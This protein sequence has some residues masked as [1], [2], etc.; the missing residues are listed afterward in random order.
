MADTLWTC[1]D[2][3]AATG[4]RASQPF[5]ASGLSIDTRSIRPGDLFVALTDR[6][7]GHDFV[8]AAFAAGAAGALVS[9][10]V[11]AEGPVLIVD[12][13]L[14]ALKDMAVAARARSPAIRT[15]VTGSVGKTSVKEMLA[16]IYA[17]AGPAHWPE[18]SFNN[19]WGVPLT[20]ARMPEATAR[21]IF[22]IGMSTPG[23]IAPRS[24]LV[25]PHHALITKI[26]PAHLEGVGSIEGVAD[27]KADIFAGLEAGGT[28][29][30]PEDDVFRDRLARQGRAACPTASLES[31]GTAREATARLVSV[32]TDGASSV[33]EI[34][35]A[36]HRAKVELAAV[37][38]HWAMNATAALLMATLTG[39]K[40]G[41]AA[42]ALRGFGP[43]PGRG[44]AQALHLPSGG[45]AL[46]V[47]D[48]YNANPES[49]R[50]A[51]EALGERRAPRRLAALGEMLEIGDGTRE[52]HAGLAGAVEAAGVT[53]VF[54]AGE[55]MGA[56]E[57]ALAPGIGCT[58]AANADSLEEKV[59]NSLRDGDVLL[60]KGSNASG[61]G[62]LADALRDWSREASASVMGSGAERTARGQDA[63]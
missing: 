56:L 62:R 28:L 51:L 36:G 3:E 31:F 23:E 8:G 15:A 37:G 54:L 20:L 58:R 55:A 41:D 18:K 4:G 6:R 14:D 53:E 52:A 25:R 48:S 49:M 47:D 61:M 35:V 12:D 7:D 21:A 13:V 34:E 27:E 38:E 22:E 46:L 17:A 11:D 10:H 1:E 60:I 40:L 43:P 9:R 45:T 24:R 42:D 39:I 5:T 33:A 16:R 19:H 26:A 50:A 63:V 32:E 2:I 30:V 44:T 59:K 57:E 29:I